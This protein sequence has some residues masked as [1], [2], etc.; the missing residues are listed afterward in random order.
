M[1]NLP[2]AASAATLV[3]ATVAA[4]PSAHAM[5]QIGAKPASF[6][7]ADTD[8]HAFQ[9]ASLTKGSPT[10]IVY[11]DKEG[12]AQNQRIRQRLEKMRE[13]DVALRA[14]HLVPIADVSPYNSWLKKGLAKS[15]LRE[16]SK[17]LGVPVFADWEGVGRAPLGA[18][19]GVSN[20]ILLD[21]QG[22][23]SWASAGQ[24][25]QAQEEAFIRVLHEVTH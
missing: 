5:L 7:V 23:V 24:L 6:A 4:A 13:T 8:D 18:A 15:A 25:S 3:L 2:I 12:S 17:D 21:K 19:S 20:L 11:V 22:R 10:L 14:V 1:R 16:E 9:L